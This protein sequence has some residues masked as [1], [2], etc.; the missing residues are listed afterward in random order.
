MMGNQAGLSRVGNVSDRDTS[1]QQASSGTYIK[2]LVML[3]AIYHG[4]RFIPFFVLHH[5]ISVFKNDTF[6]T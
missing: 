5:T 1:M 3:T 4:L 2:Y 6:G